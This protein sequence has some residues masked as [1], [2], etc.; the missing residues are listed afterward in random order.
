MVITLILD[1]VKV[2]QSFTIGRASLSK[3]GLPPDGSDYRES[4][5]RGSA[6]TGVCLQGSA[7]GWSVSKG[8]LPTWGSASGG[9]WVGQIG[10]KSEIRAVH[11]LLECFLVF[12]LF[13]P[14]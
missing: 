13:L 12:A 10:P 9:C 8:H 3:L 4:A 14:L 7:S 6:Y 2:S 5:Y 11:I 1:I